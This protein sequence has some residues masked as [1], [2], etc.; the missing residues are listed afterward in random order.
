[1]RVLVTGINGQV[2]RL[3]AEQ[4]T[5]SGVEVRGASSHPDRNGERPYPVV[6]LDLSQPESLG[7]A[8]DG[9]DRVFLYAKPDGVEQQIEKLRRAGVDRVV[10]LSSASVDMNIAPKLSTGIRAV[11][12][13]FDGS[14]LPVSSLRPGVFASNTLGWAGEI[15]K[16]GAIVLPYPNVQVNPIHEADIADAG[17]ALLTREERPDRAYQLSGPETFTMRDQ[18][19]IL[20]DGLARPIDCREVSPGEWRQTVAGAM[21]EFVIDS[22]IEIWANTDGIPQDTDHT[23]REVTGQPARTYAR[24]V[25]DHELDFA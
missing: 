18:I 13:A 3:V 2:G 23:L 25:A 1:M 4:L 11:E 17:F 14:E 6:A 12:V 24:W 21:P 10:L 20:A 16:H 19:A 22:M 9:I 15:K 7:S 8:L 5:A